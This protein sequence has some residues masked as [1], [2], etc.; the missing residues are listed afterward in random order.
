MARTPG[1]TRPSLASYYAGRPVPSR[2][3]G[4]R[5]APRRSIT[6][7][8]ASVR[9]RPQPQLVLGDLPQA[10]ESVRLDDQEEDD[11]AAKGHQLEVRNRALGDVQT[12]VPVEEPHADAQEHGKQ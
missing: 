2:A 10:C 9:E 4:R 5:R 11:Q 8:L 3:E 7:P 1:E 6:Q 12:Q